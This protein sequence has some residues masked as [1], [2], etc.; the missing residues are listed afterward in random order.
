LLGSFHQFLSYVSKRFVNFSLSSTRYPASVHLH[1]PNAQQLQP[2]NHHPTKRPISSMS[3]Y[4]S[5]PVSSAI[6]IKTIQVTSLPV[7]DDN[8][9]LPSNVRVLCS[10]LQTI[11]RQ[12]RRKQQKR[13]LEIVSPPLLR[14]IFFLTRFTNL[15]CSLPLS[16]SLTSLSLFPA[17]LRMSKSSA[18][19]IY[20]ASITDLYASESLFSARR[21]LPAA[22]AS[23]R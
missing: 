22:S 14:S 12:R 23:L 18:S 16:T 15:S 7:D 20:I 8:M 13:S 11:L 19:K 2:L 1:D 3:Q 6:P 17:S 10:R 4:N 21:P 5:F 9:Q